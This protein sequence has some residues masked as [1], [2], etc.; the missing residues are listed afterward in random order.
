MRYTNS[1]DLVLRNYL[2]PFFLG[3]LAFSFQL[4][5]LREFSVQFYGNE[6]T[7]GLILAA[8]LLWSGLG[9][10]SSAKFK[11]N[12]AHFPLAYF[13]VIFL[14]PLCLAAL[15]L[16]RVVL[17]TF[18]GETTG[19]LSIL[20]FSVVLALFVSFP[21]GTLFVFNTYFLKGNLTHVYLLE[22]LGSAAGGGVVYFLLV[23]Y[24]SNWH[25][26]A[27]IGG[28]VASVI[29]MTLGKRKHL[30][31]FLFILAYLGGFW[32]C[33]FPS[34]K[35]YW[36]PFSLVQSEDTPYGKLQV[37]RT[38]EQISVYDNHLLAYSY[39]NRASA[40]ESVHFSLLQN[41]RAEKVLLV[42]GGA[43][44]SL[45][46]ILKYPR[47]EVDF[48]EL[49][50]EIIR[51]SLR[52]LPE[53]GK[54]VLQS[55]RVHIHY[56]D[57]R[58]FINQTQN[59]Y[60]VIILNLPQPTTAQINRFYTEEFFLKIKKRLSSNGIFSYS[61]PSAENYISSEL[62]SFLS[63]LFYTTHKVFPHVKIVPGSTNIFIASAGPLTL[64]LKKINQRIRS[65][66]LNNTYVT[67]S[68]L[69]SRLNPLRIQFLRKKVTSG[70][71]TIN[72]DLTPISYFFNSVLWS[73]Q[74]QGI[75]SQ[76]FSFLAHINPFWLLDVPLILFILLLVALILRKK[77]TPF[78][79]L[80]L[81]VIGLTTIVVEIIIII[82]FQTYYGYLYKKVSFLFASFMLGVFLG[83]LRGKNRKKIHYRQ[84]VFI[85][86]GFIF[87]IFIILSL[88]KIPPPEP[89]FFLFLICMGFLGG[90]LF[91]VSNHLFL[92]EKRNYGLGNGL[93][94]LGSFSGALVASSVLIPL[95][96]LPTVL[97]YILL[98]NSFC[99]LFLLVGLF[100]K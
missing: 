67:P 18:P 37:I 11:W 71:Q 49:D 80:P 64:D 27:L 94:L 25:G 17:G 16:S 14:F 63:S 1:W 68:L 6:I 47:T 92:Q 3:F 2:P 36:K 89:F 87:L 88:L 74:F 15:R 51:L 72:H 40:E 79:M 26:V 98:L 46:Q 57:G 83:A 75:E 7:F 77:K 56:Q 96:G 43:G 28:F 60:D 31:A 65:L 61:I 44:G 99:F 52:Y 29:F 86:F 50:P 39:P 69:S 23:P 62:Q 78:L 70:P 13:L 85:Q 55:P 100:K 4:F 84:I 19:M 91:V 20:I 33:D 12:T 76:V 30:F 21:L 48:V 53:K 24:L 73:S 32:L 97:R 66:D 35:F 10:I 9:S 82:A 34:Q 81:S 45:R 22:S 59:T 8:W 42:G 58:A 54:K 41:P 93:D 5:L 90:D 38:K 95:V